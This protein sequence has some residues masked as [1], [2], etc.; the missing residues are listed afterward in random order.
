MGRFSEAGMKCGQNTTTEKSDSYD[1]L[2][3]WLAYTL[4][5]MAFAFGPLVSA[6]RP[7]MG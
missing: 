4:K 1:M 7:I 2:L 5:H 3:E 6:L